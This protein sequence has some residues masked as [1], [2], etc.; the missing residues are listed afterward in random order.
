MIKLITK[1]RIRKNSKL[2]RKVF[3]NKITNKQKKEV[4]EAQI[5]IA[6]K[7]GQ[8]KAVE[9]IKRKKKMILKSI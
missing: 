9:K 1:L 8:I 4:S 3:K 7:K 6:K 5:V 2:L